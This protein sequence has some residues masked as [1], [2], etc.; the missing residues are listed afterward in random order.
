M[1]LL[2]AQGGLGN[3]LFQ[4][5]FARALSLQT[6]EPIWIDQSRYFDPKRAQ[7]RRFELPGLSTRIA[8]ILPPENSAFAPGAV[9]SFLF[10][11]HAF[12]RHLDAG[13]SPA[14]LT[15]RAENIALK[16][17]W[18]GDVRYLYNPDFRNLLRAEFTARIPPTSPAYLQSQS[19]IRA[20]QDPV[21]VQVRRG[22]YKKMTHLFTYL[23]EGYYH[24]ARQSLVAKV[25][26]PT[27]FIFSDE[28]DFVAK[29]LAPCRGITVLPALTAFESLELARQCRHYICANSTFSWWSA[30]L[31]RW[32]DGV[33]IVP[34]AYFNDPASQA[35]YEAD[36]N[37]YPDGWIRV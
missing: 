31:S 26:D 5:A 18:A 27:W 25:P 22:E 6:S 21:C 30:F 20:A 16:G 7:L 29:E 13:Q 34:R 8:R 35:G 17:E 14:T 32:E 2:A 28:P 3:Q 36:R 23:D 19:L 24:A 4:Y 11:G 12:E 15:P 9:G 10:E 33:T 37:F 1:I